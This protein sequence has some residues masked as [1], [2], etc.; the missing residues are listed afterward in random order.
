MRIGI[1][2]AAGSGMRWPCGSRPPEPFAG[3]VV[4]DVDNH[5][6]RVDGRIPALDT[7]QTTSS[8]LPAAS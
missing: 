1:I 2:G 3:R 8:E 4:V 5:Y 6:P 7:D